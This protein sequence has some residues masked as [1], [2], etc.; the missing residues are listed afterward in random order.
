MKAKL[1]T[2]MVKNYK[3][4]VNNNYDEQYFLDNVNIIKDFFDERY[5]YAISFLNQH[6]PSNN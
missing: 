6:I 2:P 3:R 1:A 4:F 5:N